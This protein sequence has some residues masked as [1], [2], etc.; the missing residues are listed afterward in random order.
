M[1]RRPVILYVLAAAVLLGLA[2]TRH[3]PL[4]EARRDEGLN[5]FEPVENAPPLVAFT[6]VALGGFRGIFADMLWVR[7]SRL[8]MEG[9]YF[10]MVQLADWITKLEPRFTAVWAFH[11]WNLSYN[12]SV[13]FLNP[14]DR[15][16]WVRHGITLLR[17]KGLYYNPGSADLHREL[18]WIFQH[19]IGSTQDSA[20]WYYKAA[21]ASEMESLLP[22]GVLTEGE[23]PKAL[24]ES[25]GMDPQRLR[26]MEEHYGHL[27]WRLA[28]THAAY[29]A[30][31]GM[32]YAQ[33][34]SSV[35]NQRMIAQSLADAC[36]FG[37]QTFRVPLDASSARFTPGGLDPSLIAYRESLQRFPEIAPFRTGYANYLVRVIYETWAEG[38]DDRSQNL[39]QELEERFP[40]IIASK[41]R[42]ALITEVGF[43]LLH[44][45]DIPAAAAAEADRLLAEGQLRR[46]L[47][48]RALPWFVQA[49]SISKTP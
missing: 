1:S 9:R 3:R 49:D 36:L 40:E 24:R 29:W 39:Y 2:G 28:Q 41:S 48:V 18:G 35:A 12:V 21:W 38:D 13:M 32:T 30:W 20:H 47:R 43:N 25:Y 37:R 4:L 45:E 15:W 31:K 42:M 26:A 34:F 14:E 44:G 23:L 46:A 11:A 22:G 16:R 27:D 10:E 19:K 5:Q 17:D 7:A 8:Q 33:G 6:T